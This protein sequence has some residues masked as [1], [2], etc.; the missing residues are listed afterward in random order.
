MAGVIETAK[1]WLPTYLKQRSVPLPV[2]IKDVIIS[3]CDHYEPLHHVD[4]AEGIRRL[5]RWRDEYPRVNG[6]FRD[7]DGITPR[8][9]YFYPVEQND[10]DLLKLLREIVDSTKGE[11]EVH[12]H[13]END[14]PRRFQDRMRKGIDELREYGF[15]SQDA[16][17]RPR[18]GFVHGDWAL[19]N[20]H[21]QGECCGVNH[22]ISFLRDLG[23]YADFTMPSAPDHTQTRTINRIYYARDSA[24]PKSHDL[25]VE[26]RVLSSGPLAED[27]CEPRFGDL[28]M[29]Q[30]P[31]CLNWRRRKM[32]IMPRVENSDVT[33]ANP[34]T[35]LRMGLWTKTHVHVVNRPEWVFIKLHTH[36][37][38]PPN[39]DVFLGDP[40]RRFHEHLAQEY[41]ADKSWRLHYVTAREMVNMVHAAED[42]HSG[43]AG[44]FRDYRYK[45]GNGRGA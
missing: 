11:V 24:K 13:H 36:G 7:F 44:K 23:C 21:P 12:L 34:P 6:E 31:L 40:Y 38:S 42:G 2:G 4:K 45:L 25:G 43:N 9:T 8:H 16:R 27:D 33:L 35:A 20:S 5:E 3:V 22:E 26:A 41:T 15:I 14:T 1:Y 19:D 17:G 37:A 30:G 28:L 29:V 10:P 18:F 32:G 39:S